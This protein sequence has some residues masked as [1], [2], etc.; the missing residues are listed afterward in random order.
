MRVLI[1][2][3]LPRQLVPALIG[4]EAAT[5]QRMGWSAIKNGEL[6]GR[7]ALDGFDVLVTPDQNLEHQQNIA[8]AGLAIVVIRARTNR[9]EDLATVLPQLLEVLP[10]VRRGTVTHVGV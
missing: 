2:E 5:V 4:H 10:T 9:M 7:A 1:D 6:L 3:S 8:E